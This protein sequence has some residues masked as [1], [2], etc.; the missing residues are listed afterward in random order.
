MNE[1]N[2]KL[3]QHFND[4]WLEDSLF[5]PWLRKVPNNIT[6]AL[7]IAC[8]SVITAGRSELIKHSQAAKHKKAILDG[9][10]EDV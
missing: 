4:Q 6:K 7:C 9:I 8:R 10:P 3:M 1:C 5:S 2:T